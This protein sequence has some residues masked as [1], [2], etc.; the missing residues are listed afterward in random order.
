MAEHVHPQNGLPLVL[1]GVHEH[2]VPDDPRVVDHHVEPT[3]RLDRELHHLARGIPVRDVVGRHHGLA[4]ERCDLRNH[5]RCWGV[6]R[7]GSV[8]CDTEVVHHDP[9]ALSGELQR[10]RPSEAAACAG[11]DHDT[12]LTDAHA[13]ESDT[14]SGRGQTGRPPRQ[15]S[16]EPHWSMPLVNATGECH[17]S[18]PRVD[19]AGRC[20]GS[21]PRVDAAVDAAGRCRG[22]MPRVNRANE[23]VDS[24]P[25]MWQ[26]GATT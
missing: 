9:G 3:E 14:P 1:L 20:R 26:R 25:S 13:P 21:M 16:H 12:S 18:M 19:A 10:V 23:R 5:L 22:S 11:H 17:W 7:I 24:D 8:L 6:G 4:A 2:A 15:H